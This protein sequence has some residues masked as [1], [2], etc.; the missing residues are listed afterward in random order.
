MKL[1]SILFLAV[2]LPLFAAC[3]STAY[4]PTPSEMNTALREITGQNGRACV[5]I[6]D[7]AGYGT[8]SDSVL[9][10]SSK[11][12]N[13]YVMVTLHRCPAIESGAR[14]AFKGAFTDFCGGG[15]DSVH[16]G[17]G[18]CPVQSVFEFDDRDAAFAAHDQAEEMI[19]KQREAGKDG[20]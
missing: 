2:A 13:H 17:N 8:L 16:G 3:S 5:R 4:I 1:K 7:I 10:V 18:R 19:R 20:S 11:F 12:R 9:S 6:R 15:R 14:L